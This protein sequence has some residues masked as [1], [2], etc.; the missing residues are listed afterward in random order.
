MVVKLILVAIHISTPAA[1]LPGMNFDSSPVFGNILRQA[2]I[3]PVYEGIFVKSDEAAIRRCQAGEPDALRLLVERYQ[4][5]AV[6]HALV[7]VRN[8]EDAQDAVQEAFIDAFRGLARFDADRPFYPWFYV[9]LRNRCYKLVAAR[10]DHSPW[11]LEENDVPM[12]RENHC[13]TNH[14][15]SALLE[16]SREDREIL[17]LKHLDGLTYEQLSHRLE[18][19]RGTVMSRLYRARCRLRDRLERIEETKDL[20]RRSR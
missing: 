17:V 8:R 10:K 5:Q 12:F 6:A 13:E 3:L 11:S 20:L 1:G 14:V 4:T 19:P 15:E 9:I 7:I 16:L 18:I 2:R